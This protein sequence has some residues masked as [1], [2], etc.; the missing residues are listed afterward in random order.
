[1]GRSVILEP[2]VLNEHDEEVGPGQYGQLAF[3]NRLPFC[4]LD[5]YF[6][7]PEATV[8]VFSNLWFHTGD[9][10]YK[11]ESDLY[12][13]V[14]RMGGFIRTKGENLSSYQ[15]E[16]IINSHP[17]IDVCGAL[18]IPAADGEEDDIVVYVTLKEPGSLDEAALREWLVAEMPKFMWP[19]H[20]RFVDPAEDP[21]QQDRKI[22]LETND[23]RR[24]EHKIMNLAK[25]RKKI[26]LAGKNDR[27]EEP[28]GYS[29]GDGRP[30]QDHPAARPRETDSS[31]T[32]RSAFRSGDVN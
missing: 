21:D 19:K 10:C 1:M 11:D 23:P 22:K 27:V 3:R 20:I 15:I 8:K 6:N 12:Y 2:A 4:M 25:R 28:P 31:R 7:K 13:F 17:A 24:I 18:P 9:A 32:A 26:G 16:D 30:Q 5:G 29:F 14:D